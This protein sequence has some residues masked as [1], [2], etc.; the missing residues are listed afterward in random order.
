MPQ[1][2]V[3]NAS[4]AE[5]N[6]VLRATKFLAGYDFEVQDCRPG[7]CDLLV[8]FKSEFERPGGIVSGMTIMGAADVAMWL[9]IMTTRGTS[10]HWVTS[11]MKTAFLKSGIAESLI[12][13]ARI[14]KHGR[15]NAYG[16]VETVGSSSGLLAHHVIAYVKPGPPRSHEA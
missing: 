14:L 3:L 5:L 10:E 7:E 2:S 15:R 8:P 9:A 1:V 12:C 4:I 13:T 11:D 6:A 16:T